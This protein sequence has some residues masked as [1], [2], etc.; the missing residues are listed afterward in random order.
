MG[1]GAMGRGLLLRTS[2]RP[3]HCPAMG[4][5]PR[6]MLAGYWF[7]VRGIGAR[8]S[9]IV[10]ELRANMGNIRQVIVELLF[11]NSSPNCAPTIYGCLV[12]V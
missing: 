10:V 7:D 8:F 11:L 4:H 9:W 12:V 1:E 5:K 2:K 6:I 3:Q